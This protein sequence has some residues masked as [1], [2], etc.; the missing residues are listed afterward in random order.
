MPPGRWRQEALESIGRGVVAGDLGE[1]HGRDCFEPVN[2]HSSHWIPAP[3]AN[4]LYFVYL[5]SGVSVTAFYAVR[6]YPGC[7]GCTGHLSQLEALTTT[8]S[9]ELCESI[10]DP[11]PG[12]GRYD[13]QTA[14]FGDICAWKTK[15]VAGYTV[16][17]EWSNRAN[18]CT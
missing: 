11:I 15:T 18:T 3:T 4:G 16:Q 17:Q 6:P 1:L 8:S 12:T 9:H 13:D 2:T 7:A 5:P 10:T 14:R